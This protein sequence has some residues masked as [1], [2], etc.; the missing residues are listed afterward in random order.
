MGVTFSIPLQGPH[1]CRF[2]AVALSGL[3]HLPSSAGRWLLYNLTCFTAALE[4]F[5][6]VLTD[7]C[8]IVAG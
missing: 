6:V 5:H 1:N 7:S 8:T 2:A 4:S 3:Y